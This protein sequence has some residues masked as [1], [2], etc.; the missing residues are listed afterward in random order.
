MVENKKDEEKLKKSVQTGCAGGCLVV[1][2]LLVVG[3]VFFAFFYEPESLLSHETPYVND[4]GT[5]MEIIVTDSTITRDQAKALINHYRA[6]SMEYERDRV[7]GQ[8]IVKHKK[9]DPVFKDTITP[10]FVIFNE[11]PNINGERYLWSD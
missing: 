6:N 3:I 8:V 4:S 5:R 10:T 9:L 7:R 2:F 1:V 11:S